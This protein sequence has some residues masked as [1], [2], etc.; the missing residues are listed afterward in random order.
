MPTTWDSEKADLAASRGITIERWREGWE[1]AAEDLRAA[2]DFVVRASDLVERCAARTDRDAELDAACAS[3]QI[4]GA[5]ARRASAVERLRAAAYQLGRLGSWS[6]E[7][8]ERHARLLGEWVEPE[9]EH[10]PDDGYDGPVCAADECR[11]RHGLTDG[12]CYRHSDHVT[13]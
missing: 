13:A 12:Y 9:A 1:R 6:D 4:L 11:F 7:D 2:E 10:E 3:Q 8:D 5:E